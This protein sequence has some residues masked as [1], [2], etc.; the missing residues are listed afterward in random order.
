MLGVNPVTCDWQKKPY[1]IM[2]KSL[3]YRR[4]KAIWPK[5][6]WFRFQK[7]LVETQ[8]QTNLWI[9]GKCKALQPGVMHDKNII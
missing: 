9:V 8:D 3:I 7:Y 2:F 5:M 4:I 6:H 1:V